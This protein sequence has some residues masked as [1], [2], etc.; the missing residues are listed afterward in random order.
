MKEKTYFLNTVLAVVLCIALLA[1]VLLRT[2]IPAI[3]LPELDLPMMVLLSLIALLIDHYAA[4]NAKRCYICIPVFAVITFGLLPF[5]A[6]MFSA[7][8]AVKLAVLGGAVFTLVTW[9]FTSM[10]ER[11]ASGPAAKAAP[12]VS[13]LCMYCAAQCLTGI[14]I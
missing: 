13:A 14:L 8:E 4:K 2:F 10:Q 12:V 3:I 11:I 7:M 1:A 5:A 9:L 6:G